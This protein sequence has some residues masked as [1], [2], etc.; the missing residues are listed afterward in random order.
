MTLE[1]KMLLYRAKHNLSQTELAKKCKVTSQTIHMVE[2]GQQKP[3]RLTE[4]KIRLVIEEK[5]D[6]DQHIES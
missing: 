4:A 1:E 3:S 5:E 2:S 6:G